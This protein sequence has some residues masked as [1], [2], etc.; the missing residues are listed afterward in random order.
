MG[1]A[2]TLV[3]DPVSAPKWRLDCSRCN[4][5]IYLPSD[6]HAVRVSRR[7]CEVTYR[8]AELQCTVLSDEQESLLVAMY[9]CSGAG[10]ACWTEFAALQASDPGLQIESSAVPFRRSA[11]LQP[12]G[13]SYKQATVTS[14]AEVL[15]CMQY[16]Q[17]LQQ[18]Q[19]QISLA[20]REGYLGACSLAFTPE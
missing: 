18:E 8:P 4:F 9:S 5:L 17:P 12:G 14:H 10:R 7:T 3:L 2:G 20:A 1:R 16:H 6:L 13:T 15:F 11:A 19:Q